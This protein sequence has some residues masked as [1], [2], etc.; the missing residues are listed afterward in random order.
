[1]MTAVTIIIISVIIAIT[2][3]DNHNNNNNN[4]Y[5][6][7]NNNNINDKHIAINIV[8]LVV[9]SAKKML[10]NFVLVRVD[11]GLPAGP[12]VRLAC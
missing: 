4:N 12:H 11:V 3:N 5:N 10:F 2:K 1:M 9:H 6:N 8:F 7:N